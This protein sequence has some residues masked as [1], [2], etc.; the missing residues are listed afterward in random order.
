MC[1]RPFETRSFPNSLA[2]TLAVLPSM[3]L[4]PKAPFDLSVCPSMSLVS[5]RL[6]S[7][8]AHAFRKVRAKDDRRESSASSEFLEQFAKPAS[9]FITIDLACRHVDHQFFPFGAIR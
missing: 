1:S 5:P 4:F 3:S 9:G 6:H 8:A 2:A 7:F